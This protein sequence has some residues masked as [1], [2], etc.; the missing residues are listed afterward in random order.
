M[1]QIEHQG[2]CLIEEQELAGQR[3]DVICVKRIE[4]FTRALTAVETTRFFLNDR[5]VKKSKKVTLNDTVRVTWIEDV[6][7]ELEKEDIPLSI[8]FE[9]EDILVINKE[10]GISVHAGSGESGHTLVN[11]LAFY[12]GDDFLSEMEDE[13]IDRFR[14]GIVHRLDKPTSG[15]LV[16]AK[17]VDALL[18]L[19]KQ[20]RKRTSDK[21]YIA[22]VEGEFNMPYG[23]IENNLVRDERHRTRFAVTESP[24]EGK[25]AITEYDVLKQYANCALV[26]IHLVTGR[27]HQ[28]RVHMASIGHPVVGDTLYGNRNSKEPLLLH[29]SSLSLTH[30]STGE[31]VTFRSPMP[32]RIESYLKR[33]R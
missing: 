7:D 5:E 28:I 21:Y 33:I 9:D 1:E 23:T 13:R 6:I 11:A 29:A 19:K 27:T 24:L 25:H 18:S 10:P 16:V 2:T 22:V 4:D 20:F 32:H 31:S 30:P 3:I 15:T 26:R 8:L 17:R 12:L 14:P